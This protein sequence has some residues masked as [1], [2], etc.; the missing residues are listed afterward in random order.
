[1]KI[2]SVALFCFFFIVGCSSP[3]KVG[4]PTGDSA[5]IPVNQIQKS[6]A[7]IIED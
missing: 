4:F 6:P 2:L 1:M 3:P 5:R 7:Q